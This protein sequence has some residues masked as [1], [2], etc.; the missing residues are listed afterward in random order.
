MGSNLACVKK[1]CLFASLGRIRIGLP[2]VHGRFRIGLIQVKEEGW[3]G[4]S[5]GWQ[6]KARGKS[7]GTFLPARGKPRPTRLFYLDLHSI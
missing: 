2:K 7:H 6:G 4:F 1:K 5:E 3:T